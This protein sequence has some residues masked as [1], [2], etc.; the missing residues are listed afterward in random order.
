MLGR[1]SCWKTSIC[2]YLCPGT[3]GRFE[4]GLFW[5]KMVEVDGE[6]TSFMNATPQRVVSRNDYRLQAQ[7]PKADICQSKQGEGIA[8]GQIFGCL[9][10][11]AAVFDEL[12]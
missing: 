8:R 1:P 7:R 5:S 11:L 6:S 9:I 12:P 10:Y 3:G 4:H 2:I